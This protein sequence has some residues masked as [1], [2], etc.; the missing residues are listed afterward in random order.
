MRRKIEAQKLLDQG[1]I[2][3]EAEKTQSKE[4]DLKEKMSKLEVNYE[5]SY[6]DQLNKELEDAY[7]KIDSLMQENQKMKEM[8]AEA[9]KNVNKLS[10]QLAAITQE[11]KELQKTKQNLEKKL[12]AINKKIYYLSQMI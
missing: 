3:S 11:K 4:M 8:I 12:T 10:K 5:E 6:D 2:K 9:D 1:F 7:G